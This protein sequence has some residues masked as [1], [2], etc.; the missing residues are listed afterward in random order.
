M[1]PLLLLLLIVL[2]DLGSRA[3]AWSL[4]QSVLSGRRSWARQASAS[5]VGDEQF[6]ALDK[7][8]ATEVVDRRDG[9]VCRAT[10]DE[11]FGKGLFGK[12]LFSQGRRRVLVLV[13]PQLGEFDS[14]EYIEQVVSVLPALEKNSIALRVIG[15]GDVKSA[16]KFSAFTGL[17]LKFLMVDPSANLHEALGCHRGPNWDI[18]SF[19]PDWALRL[20]A[21][22][23]GIAKDEDIRFAKGAAR[24][25]LNYMAMCAGI[26]APGTLCEILR[27]YV[28]DKSAPERLSKQET[29][30]T[31][32]VSITGTRDVKIGPISYQNAWKDD[33][34]YQRPVELATVRLRSMVEVLSNF[35]EYVPDQSV[36]DWPGA[37]FLFD[38]DGT[39]LYGYKSPGVLTYS[40]TM[41]RPLSFLVDYIGKEKARNP[42]GLG[43]I[44]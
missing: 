2:V 10:D 23:I 39:E 35:D 31:G 41:G 5:S 13:L 1:R 30:S 21:E 43:D 34:G 15:I 44:S 8:S 4:T 7:L 29:D 3:W 22:N 36:L 20:F 33:V 32:P 12:A 14:C 42:L 40:A 6:S 17:P 9:S 18:P 28:G 37:T 27:G 11:L 25:W 16:R 24:A 38:S 19:V 26:S